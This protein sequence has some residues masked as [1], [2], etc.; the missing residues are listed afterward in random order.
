AETRTIYSAFAFVTVGVCLKLAL[1]PLH[2]WLPN[3]YTY[4][5]SA[6]TAFVASTAT[7][8]AIYVLL[9]FVLTMFGVA[10]SFNTM[11][12]GQILMALAVM[13]ILIPSTVA[14]YQDNIKRLFAYSSVG[15]V[16]STL[17]C[18][19]LGTV[20]RLSAGLLHIFNHALTKGGLSLALG[21]LYYRT[22]SVQLHAF[23]GLGKTM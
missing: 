6:A 14:I 9:R 18:I 4:A 12:L 19:S 17:L 23:R 13:A 11:P 21:C 3:A 2:G 16:G 10:F 8:V 5:P 7:K 15:Q 22:G 20:L 1:F